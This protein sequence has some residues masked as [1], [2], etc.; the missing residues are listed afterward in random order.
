MSSSGSPTAAIHAQN[1]KPHQTLTA[2]FILT[3]A[4][5]YLDACTFIGHGGIFANA[6]SGNIVIAIFA[7]I[8]FKWAEAAALGFA[9]LAFMLAILVMRWSRDVPWIRHPASTALTF[10]IVALLVLGSLG[11]WAGGVVSTTVVAFVAAIQTSSFRHLRGWNYATTMT[12]TNLRL[13][14]ESGYAAVRHGSG[15]DRI[16]AITFGAIT[17]SFA[18]GAT[19]GGLLT[20]WFGQ[21]AF[22]GAAAVLIVA[23]IV[24]LAHAKRYGTDL[25]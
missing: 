24:I 15:Y 11:D 14:V 18:I 9:L 20:I 6:M 4:G 12:T 1:L 23:A 13:M 3:I 8:S 16:K 5:G 2:G 10:E 22:W 21:T 19:I 17:L 7:A 25:P